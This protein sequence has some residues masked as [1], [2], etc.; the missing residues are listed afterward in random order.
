MRVTLLVN[1]I[2]RLICGIVES[3][4]TI[5]QYV[6]NQLGHSLDWSFLQ[7]SS[8]LLSEVA[9][10]KRYILEE[11]LRLSVQII[12]GIELCHRVFGCEFNVLDL[13]EV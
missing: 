9:L 7:M 3:S 11:S 6:S 12:C 2:G 8:W 5:E 13:H 1:F 10:L 4:G